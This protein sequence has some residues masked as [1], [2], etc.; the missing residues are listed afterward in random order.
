MASIQA[1]PRLYLDTAQPC[2]SVFGN[3][4][5]KLHV[6]EL[7]VVVDVGLPPE[8]LE[9]LLGQ[10]LP[11]RRGHHPQLLHLNEAV[12]VLVKNLECLFQVLEETEKKRVTDIWGV[13][14]LVFL[15]KYVISGAKFNRKILAQV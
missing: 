3:H 9:L 15:G 4:V 11:E 14:C 6:V 1:R 7:P 8:L 10:F 5:D 2:L 12:L 13:D